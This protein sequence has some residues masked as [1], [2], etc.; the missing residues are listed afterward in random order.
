MLMELGL[1]KEDASSLSQRVT[2]NR[3]GKV[4]I[5]SLLELLETTDV[6]RSRRPRSIVLCGL[7][8]SLTRLRR[9]ENWYRYILAPVTW[10][11]L[12][13]IWFAPKLEWH[14]V[15]GSKEPCHAQRE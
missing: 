11:I 2:L 8:V 15:G 10:T 3:K 5:S 4:K 14:C 12:Q 7:G 9:W 1:A 6:V 13:M